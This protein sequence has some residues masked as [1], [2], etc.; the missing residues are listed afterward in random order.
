MAYRRGKVS[1]TCETCGTEFLIFQC[2]LRDG[3][4][5]R[6]CSRRC[7]AIGCAKPK[8][9]I[10]CT[11]KLCG[12]DF[13]VR[14]GR[15]GTGEF[16]SIQ[17]MAQVRGLA[18]RGANHPKWNNGSSERTHAS[19]RTIESRKKL[20]G[21]CERCGSKDRLQGHHV[22]RHS[23]TPHRRSDP[24]NIEIL[25]AP[26]HALEHPDLSKFILSTRG[27]YVEKAMDI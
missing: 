14:K 15:G 22:E 24:S 4:A 10:D 18:M 3:K 11:C 5:G 7:A 13:K 26:C 23:S 1:R 2:H 16:C 20:V 12:K 6:F 27:A 8:T 17:C 25:C 9:M 19:R 21:C